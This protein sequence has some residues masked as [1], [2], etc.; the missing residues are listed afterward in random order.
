MISNIRNI[1]HLK[2]GFEEVLCGA[3]GK[4][5]TCMRG[6]NS[7]SGSMTA[8][9]LFRNTAGNLC[10]DLV[11]IRNTMHVIQNVKC[12]YS[13]SMVIVHIF[14]FCIYSRSLYYTMNLWITHKAHDKNNQKENLLRIQYMWECSTICFLIMH[15]YKHLTF[16]K[17]TR[18]K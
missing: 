13:Q 14:L 3:I 5:P 11:A 2:I 4:L 16:A 18:K 17:H 6:S 10:S 9:A 15:G 12:N 8:D 1:I 7:P